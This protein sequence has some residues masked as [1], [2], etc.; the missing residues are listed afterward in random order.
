MS[1]ASYLHNRLPCASRDMKS[2]NEIATGSPGDINN[3]RIFGTRAWVKKLDNE[4]K[5]GDKVKPTAFRGVYLGVANHQK[6]CKFYIEETN[7][8]VVRESAT[9][10]TSKAWNSHGLKPGPGEAKLVTERKAGGKPMPL[11]DHNNRPTRARNPPTNRLHPSVSVFQTQTVPTPKSPVPKS[12]KQ[13]VKGE[14][15]DRWIKAAISELESLKSNDVF[16]E[17]NIP[18]NQKLLYMLWVL[19]KKEDEHGNVIRFKART[20][21]NGKQQVEGIHFTE[22]HASVPAHATIRAVMSVAAAKKMRLRQ[23]D[24]ETAFLNS[25]LEEEIYVVPPFG[26][27]VPPGRCW[28]LKKCIYGLRQASR[29]WFNCL[30]SALKKAGLRQSDADPC[31]FIGKD[32]MGRDYYL[33]FHVDDIMLAVSDL[34]TEEMLYKLLSKQFKIK[35]MGDISWFL[36]MKITHLPCGGYRVDQEKY[37]SDVLKRFGAYDVTPIDTP[38]DPKARLAEAM[39]T[40]LQ[41]E[42]VEYATGKNLRLYKEIL[43]SVLYAAT[44]TRPDIACV[45]GLLSRAMD[46]PR[47]AHWDGVKRLLRYLRGTLSLGLTYTGNVHLQGY[48]DANWGGDTEKRSTSGFVFFINGGRY[49]GLRGDKGGC[50]VFMRI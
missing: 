32:S 26:S 46:S 2:P 47:K 10:D 39:D 48:T 23:W 34:K 5:K 11:V 44:M 19:A 20:C 3:L 27:S 15:R 13:A 29:S 25:E 14:D 17:V 8:L 38:G 42:E 43:G 35:K 33:V 49:R 7:R 50:V 37:V 18:P 36:G 6:G 31:L 21:V 1:H 12:M 40:P 4:I 22:T 45:V 30:A 16:E 9:Y 41:P 28:R 24:F